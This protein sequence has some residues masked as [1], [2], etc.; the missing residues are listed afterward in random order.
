MKKN[1]HLLIVV[2]LFT[3]SGFCKNGS[4]EINEN[5]NIF[6]N[7][8]DLPVFYE[9]NPL[10]DLKAFTVITSFPLKDIDMKKQIRQSIEKT[11]SR[12]GEIIHLKDN[13]M[14]GFGTGNV[15][16]IQMGNVTAWDG[17][18]IPVSRVSL[19]IETFVSLDKTGMKTFP[20]IWS[21]N[22]FLQGTVGSNSEVNL[23]RAVQKLIDDFVQSYQYA[24]QNQTKRPVFYIYD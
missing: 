10:T 16:L 8:Q 23:T 21:I 15:F 9:N 22:T 7:P 4:T 11:L 3:A 20:M 2:I 13:D 12:T 14:R 24:N 1:I 18:E 17:S 5:P 19:S 6:R